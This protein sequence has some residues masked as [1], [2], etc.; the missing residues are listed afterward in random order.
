MYR[1]KLLKNEKQIYS[2]NNK[3]SVK[4]W[5]LADKRTSDKDAKYRIVD[6]TK[7]DPKRQAL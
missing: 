1:Y 5:M 3:L 2:S 6:N 4:S 7:L